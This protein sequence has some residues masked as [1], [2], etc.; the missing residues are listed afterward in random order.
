MKLVRR[1][2]EAPGKIVEV[3]MVEVGEAVVGPTLAGVRGDM[4]L[5]V[6]PDARAEVLGTGYGFCE[7]PA[8]DA[9]GNVYFSDGQ[10]NTIHFYEL[11]KSVTVFVDDSTDANG[12]M[13][14]A[15]G[16]L[17]VCEGAAYQ[18]VAFDVKTKE[19]RVLASEI[20]GNH[21]NE[22]ND[23]AIDE[24]GG[25][26]FTDP[27]YRHRNQPTVMKEDTYY[28]SAEGEII[29]VSTVYY[30]D[31][32]KLGYDS[33]APLYGS[34]NEQILT[35]ASEHNIPVARVDIAF[36]GPAGDQSADSRYY[37][38]DG[39]H[40]SELGATIIADAHRELGYEATC[41]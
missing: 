10:N 27:N 18:V 38:A 37:G 30:G 25:F 31:L 16:E 41:R 26:Y 24:Y 20:D 14:N 40:P 6:A 33:A 15:K 3:A 22:P 4:A 12:M 19:K 23:L 11:G 32:A 8:A 1:V 35:S 36:N 39:L 28:C 7:G 13:F 9:Q 2:S 34:L 5:P 29:R 21:F 17:Y